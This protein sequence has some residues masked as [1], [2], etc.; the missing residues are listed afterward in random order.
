MRIGVDV[1]G[2]NTD[3]VLMDGDLVLAS[4]KM[5]T[6]ANVSDGI[7]AA[8][9]AIL[10]ETGTTGDA[11]D[12][13]MIGTTHFTNAFVQAKGLSQVFA[14]RIGAPAGRGIPPFSTW[15]DA[16]KNAVFG[17]FAMIGGGYEFDGRLIAPLDEAAITAAAEEIKAKGIEQ[18]AIAGIFSQLNAEQEIRAAELIKMVVPSASISLSSQLGRVGLLERE[19]AAIMNASLRALADHVADAFGRALESLGITA[20]FFVSQNDGTLMPTSL[21]RQYPVLTFAAGPT[22]SLRGAAWL[23]GLKNAIVVDIGGTTTDVGVLVNGFPRQSSVHVDVGGVRTNFRMPDILSIGLGGGSRIRADGGKVTVGPDS[24]AFRLLEE[25]KIFGGQTLTAS[26]IAVASGNADFGDKSLVETLDPGLVFAAQDAIHRLAEDGIDRMKTSKDDIPM[27][28]VGG[29]HVLISRPLEGVSEAH[30]PDH[31]G[32]ANAVGAAIGQI[33]GEVD[34]I[35]HIAEDTRDEALQDAKTRASEAA[36][37]AGAN[38]DTIEIV[39]LEAV[40]LQY[41]PGG[42]TRVVCR[43][44]GDLVMEKA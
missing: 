29:G 10:E 6:T 17:G 21:L 27:I 4:R 44:V 13:V 16:M 32:V 40:P 22:N 33:S 15:P 41:L 20:P 23:T 8:I 7:E 5:P 35:Y 19:N 31:A 26:D 28:L 30:A 38:P 36:I 24:V 39:N 18:V 14:L 2:T 37:A 9:G 1:G 34:R 11:I 43:A 12:C 25:A 42:A 3:A